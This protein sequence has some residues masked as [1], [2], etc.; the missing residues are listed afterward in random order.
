MADLGCGPGNVTEL[1]AERWP[2]ARITGF[3]NSAEMLREARGTR[4]PPRRR[5]PRLPL[6]RRRALDPEETYD[7]IVSNAALQWVPGHADSFARWVAA[8]RPGGTFA[9]QVPG[10]FTSPSHALLGELSDSR[11][12][13]T[14]WPGTAPAS[15]TSST[16]WSTWSGWSPSAARWTPGRPPTSRC[17]RGPTRYW[18]GSRAPRCGRCSPR[19]PTT[20]RPAR[21]SSPNTGTCSARRIRRVRT[22]RPS[23]SAGSSS[24][25]AR[26]VV[27]GTAADVRPAAPPG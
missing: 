15:C 13:A 16:P 19:S 24:S 11:A 2:T 7:L 18:T 26:R 27:S 22:A 21:S 1:L 9:F 14:G 12:G 3:D 25:P 4:A 5:H 8:L 17:S 6:R 10:N 20:P 23:R